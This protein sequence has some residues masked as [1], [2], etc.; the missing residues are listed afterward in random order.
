M[1]GFSERYLAGEG[2][3]MYP[4]PVG[5]TCLHYSEGFDS[6]TLSGDGGERGGKSRVTRLRK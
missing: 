5:S 3:R 1:R 2:K 4:L 6:Y